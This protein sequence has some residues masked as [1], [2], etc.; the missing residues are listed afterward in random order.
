M[1]VVLTF[2][3]LIVIPH[4][5]TSSFC[6]I[7][8]VLHTERET[9]IQWDNAPCFEEK[10]SLR[11]LSPCSVLQ[12]LLPQ[13]CLNFLQP[14]SPTT[15]AAAEEIKYLL[16]LSQEVWE[17]GV[18][19]CIPMFLSELTQCYLCTGNSQC[20][21]CLPGWRWQGS[22]SSKGGIWKWW[23][24]KDECE[25]KRATHVQVCTRQLAFVSF[26]Q[27]LFYFSEELLYIFCVGCDECS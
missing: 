10:E 15:T 7:T 3:Y 8:L 9:Q 16:I 25:G 18:T 13:L 23:M 21:F 1:G 24:G 19:L 2:R 6:N 11:N 4:M 22:G 27:I 14:G 5:K 17:E 26:S 12:I 20:I